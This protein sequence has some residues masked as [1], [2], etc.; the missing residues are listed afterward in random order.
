MTPE[1]DHIWKLYSILYVSMLGLIAVL[2]VI[3]YLYMTKGGRDEVRGSG[4][5]S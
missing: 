1:A 3:N 5:K 4:S 2:A